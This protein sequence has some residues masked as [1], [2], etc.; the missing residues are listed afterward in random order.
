MRVVLAAALAGLWAGSGC[1]GGAATT[2]TTT[3][4]PPAG[5]AAAT[6]AALRFGACPQ[7][8][9]G[10][11]CARLTV[12]LHRRGPHAG[13]GRMLALDVAVQRR[14]TRT[15]RRDLLMLSGGPG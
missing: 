9:P 12:P 7:P 2:A 1:G 4:R 15:A 3:T 10:F 6:P 14:G 13:D 8:L 11:R 5:A